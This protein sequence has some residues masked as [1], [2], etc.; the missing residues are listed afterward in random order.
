MKPFSWWGNAGLHMQVNKSL[1]AASQQVRWNCQATGGYRRHKQ[2][3]HSKKKKKGT[4][5][6]WIRD[7]SVEVTQPF[8]FMSQQKIFTSSFGCL[9]EE[10][11]QAAVWSP[12]KHFFFL[13]LSGLMAEWNRCYVW[14]MEGSLEQHTL[15]AWI[16]FLICKQAFCSVISLCSGVQRP[17]QVHGICTQAPFMQGAEAQWRWVEGQQGHVCR[18]SEVPFKQ[19]RWKK[20]LLFEKTR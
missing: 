6:N 19:T 12:W 8:V 14:H 3:L 13:P 11:G 4:E 2:I 1:A 17:F 18:S 16:G 10:Y 20:D 7:T 9:R 15:E 5:E